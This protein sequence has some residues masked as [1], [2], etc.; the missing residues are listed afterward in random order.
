MIPACRRLQSAVV[1]FV[2]CQ[3]VWAASSAEAEQRLDEVVVRGE[4]KKL[5]DL[6]KEV[7]ELEDR[8]YSLY[9]TLNVVDD[10]DVNCRQETPTGS[11][12]KRRTCRA[13]YQDRALAIEGRESYEI[14]QRVNEPIGP[15][16]MPSAPPVP[17]Y[18]TIEARRREFRKN[19]LEVVRSNDELSQLLLDRA[20]AMSRYEAEQNRIFNKKG[21]KSVRESGP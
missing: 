15:L 9:N 1:L 19:M 8:F 16:V 2:V 6:R 21:A 13:V 14:H 3:G 10:F 11:R 4:Q 7:V 18:V 20:E 5:D 17:A 12:L